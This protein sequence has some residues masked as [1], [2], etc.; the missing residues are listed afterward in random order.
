MQFFR[1][2]KVYDKVPRWMAA[3]DGLQGHYDEVAGHQ[4]RRPAE[5]ELQS[6]ASRQGDQDGFSTGLIC[7][8]PSIG[9]PANDFL[10]VCK[11]SR[12]TR[13]VAT[14]AQELSRSK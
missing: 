6:Q 12:Q 3:R 11:Q 8:H 9:V 5:P 4:E 10:H 2:M 14:L 1:N 7:R 13:S